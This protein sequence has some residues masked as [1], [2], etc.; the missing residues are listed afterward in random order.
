[1]SQTDIDLL[2]QSPLF[3]LSLAS[4]ELFHS[5]FLAWLFGQRP[6]WVGRIL[7]TAPEHRDWVLGEKG[8]R[9]EERN[10]DLVIHLA[11]GSTLIVENKVKS[12][13]YTEQLERY[14]TLVRDAKETYPEPHFLLL[15]LS[16]GDAPATATWPVVS[17]GE[18]AERLAQAATTLADGYER[19]LVEDY[20]SFIR[21][22]SVLGVTS[23]AD[24]WIDDRPLLRELRIADLLQKRKATWLA[25]NLTEGLRARG[26][27]GLVGPGSKASDLRVGELLV[28]DGLTNGNGLVGFVL[29]IS[30]GPKLPGARALPRYGFGVQI[31]G[32]Q[33]RSFV[34]LLRPERPG[35]DT[36]AAFRRLCLDLF[37]ASPLP[38]WW[39]AGDPGDA[40]KDLCTYGGV[41]LYRYTMLSKHRSDPTPTLN[42]LAGRLAASA[43]ALVEGATAVQN[44]LPGRAPH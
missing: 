22:L 38:G 21:S 26:F 39:V 35:A 31:Q 34:E 12:V 15:T 17:Y 40:S 41:F 16:P 33:Y 2:R 44:A 23:E 6:D 43:S 7:G 11:N 25:R 29:A 20:A 4:R 24:P 18:M 37:Q 13:P 3:Q 32:N 28:Y 19:H 42:T 10:L 1:M 36:L 9:R 14:E 5:N 30:D 8:I 27:H